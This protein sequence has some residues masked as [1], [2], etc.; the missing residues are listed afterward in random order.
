MKLNFGN[1]LRTQKRLSRNGEGRERGEFPDTYFFHLSFH[2]VAL[3][4]GS[5]HTSAW[6]AA[7]QRANTLIHMLYLWVSKRAP[8]WLENERQ[9]LRDQLEKIPQF[10]T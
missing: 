4:V 7:A 8:S 3:R 2:N 6:G 9:D 1:S 5:S 10:F